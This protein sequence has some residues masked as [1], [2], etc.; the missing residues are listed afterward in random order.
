MQTAGMEV[1][2]NPTQQNP[3]TADLKN[4]NPVNANPVGVNSA[5]LL[6]VCGEE[7][8]RRI[9]KVVLEASGYRVIEART[10]SEG[11]R[12]CAPQGRRPALTVV[13]AELGGGLWASLDLLRSALHAAPL[14]VMSPEEV[15]WLLDTLQG[16]ELGHPVSQENAFA[17]RDGAGM[18]ASGPHGQWLARVRLVLQEGCVENKEGF[19]ALAG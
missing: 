11:M 14:L 16:H 1:A 6:L 8:S 2:M 9:L 17:R 12:H 18:V 13:V 4:V 7:L 3:T 19:F 10:V 15:G 5:L